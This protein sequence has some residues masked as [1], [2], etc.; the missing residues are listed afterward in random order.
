MAYEFKNRIEIGDTIRDIKRL[1]G[2][3]W[4]MAIAKMFS[5]L[6]KD[7]QVVAV[8]R[9][10]NVFELHSEYIPRG[11]RNI[12]STEAQIN[13]SAKSLAKHFDM[14]AAVYLRGAH[15]QKKSLEFMAHHETGK[16]R[17]ANS[18]WTSLANNEYL[19][20]P[21]SAYK[22][23]KK[24]KVRS[25]TKTRSGRVRKKYTPTALLSRFS[26][27]GSIYTGGT[28]RTPKYPGRRPNG[29]A[30]IPGAPFII[31]SRQTGRPVIV[32]RTQR[33]ASTSEGYR[34]GKLETL[35]TLHRKADIKGQEWKFEDAVIVT[36]KRGYKRRALEASAR[37]AK[38]FK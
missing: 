30:K 8:A 15:D 36:A 5:H 11:I 12:P 17:D 37:V 35:Y 20:M 1:H 9:T 10:R 22:S 25:E 33:G 7:S 14:F 26:E 24:G 2:K 23:G 21:G 28:T 38:R 34:S 19:A 6:S 32:R 16:K 29:R 4:P 3:E 13:Q 31:K 18:S 27:A